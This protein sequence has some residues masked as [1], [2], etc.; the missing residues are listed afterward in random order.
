[1][2]LRRICLSAAMTLGLTM[3]AS[4]QSTVL[5]GQFKD[6]QAGARNTG[7]GKVCFVISKPQSEEPKGV[8]RDPVYF[9]VTHRPSESVRNEVSLMIGYPFKQDSKVTIQVGSDSF[10]LFTNR[11]NAWLADPN[12]EKRLIN[13]MRAGSNMVIKGTSRRGTLT[14]DQYSLSGISAA[15]NKINTECP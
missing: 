1:M 15:L 7:K 4:A 6:W 11:D 10:L 12:E 9:F 5:L 3:S 2:N 8:N 14:T 13:A